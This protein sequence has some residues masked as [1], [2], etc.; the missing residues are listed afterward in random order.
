MARP[1]APGL[2]LSV[3]LL[4][5]FVD[6]WPLKHAAAMGAIG[7]GSMSLLASSLPPE[8][9]DRPVERHDWGAPSPISIAVAVEVVVVSDDHPSGGDRR[10]D[11]HGADLPRHECVPPI[12]CDVARTARALLRPAAPSVAQ[13][14]D[15]AGP[16]V[17]SR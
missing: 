7:V 13:L 14:A 1:V 12:G 11:D 6:R 15:I 9:H 8:R 4:G 3:R 5:H 16:L 2:T 17:Q 10:I